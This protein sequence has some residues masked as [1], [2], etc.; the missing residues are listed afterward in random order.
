M[1]V[2]GYQRLVAAGTTETFDDKGQRALTVVTT[3]SPSGGFK[4][5]ALKG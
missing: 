4:A 1:P 3:D 5:V 2:M